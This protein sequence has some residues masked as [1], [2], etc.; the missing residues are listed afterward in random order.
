MGY[1]DELPVALDSLRHPD[2]RHGSSSVSA[3]SALSPISG[4]AVPESRSVLKCRRRVA[5]TFNV[6][7]LLSK[8]V[9]LSAHDMAFS[10]SAQMCSAAAIVCAVKASGWCSIS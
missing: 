1:R 10:R 2:S 7:I 8:R 4:H 6:E 5:R 3:S 9:K